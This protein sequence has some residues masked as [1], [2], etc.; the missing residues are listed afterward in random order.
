N[1]NEIAVGNG[2]DSSSACDGGTAALRVIRYQSRSDRSCAYVTEAPITGGPP[3][4]E[5]TLAFI[6]THHLQ[7][8]D[9]M[10]TAAFIVS[11]RQDFI[12]ARLHFDPAGFPAAGP[13]MLLAWT[14]QF[15]PQLER[16]MA[17][18]LSGPPSDGPLRASLLSDTP[19]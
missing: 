9:T 11:D 16:G 5:Q 10:L 6:A 3:A 1:T 18:Q 8:P 4:W 7:V 17:N 13:R 14:A 19:V 12:D 2:W 15:A